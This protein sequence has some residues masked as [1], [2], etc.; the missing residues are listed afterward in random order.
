[1]DMFFL[2]TGL[3]KGLMSKLFFELYT[4][5]HFFSLVAAVHA[6]L[7]VRSSQG[8][9]AW[10]VSLIAFPPVALPLYLVF[11]RNKFHGYIE[12]LREINA[13]NQDSLLELSRTVS[14]YRLAIPGTKLKYFDKLTQLSAYRDNCVEL[15]IDGHETFTAIFDAIDRA[16]KYIL[17]EFFIVRDD[18]LG[19]RLKDHLTAKAR[20]G[21]KIF[22]LYDEVG[23]RSLGKQYI[24]Q[25]RRAG[26]NIL[27]F[28]STKGITNRFQINFRNHRKIVVV[29]GKVAFIGGHNVGDE[30][31]GHNADFGHWR[32][33]H[34]RIKGPAAQS[35][36]LTFTE[37]WY[38]SAQDKPDIELTAEPEAAG[39]MDAIV[40]PSGPASRLEVCSLMF[41]QLI[42]RAKKRLWIAS[43]YFVPDSAITS[44]LQLAA[45]RGVDIRI[46][47]PFKPDHLMVYLASYFY[48]SQLSFL[49][50]RFFRYKDGFMHQKVVLV[51]D[52]LALVGTANIDNRS[53]YLNF[54]IGILVNDLAFASEVE[55]M[56]EAD[57]LKC[58]ESGV[59]D[60]ENKSWFFKLGVRLS[61]LF[62][63]M[64]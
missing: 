33:T 49:K 57:F 16:D 56:L 19:N 63:P 53:L 14:K 28:W 29:D 61:H 54:E 27:P 2:N 47:L 6:G 18:D 62:A 51:D 59:K 11:G 23:S 25:M 37:D 5:F 30:Y 46:I 4:I 22:F 55:K 60:Y 35:V 43:P 64:L 8:A 40:L 34:V 12:T 38:W 42:N 20:A 9:V 36:Q 41:V 52:D 1:M 13:R 31:L 7:T 24:S 32:D 26:I 15:L 21:I 58:Q 39:D 10:S 44:A 45:L 3:L 17:I 48:L 50:I